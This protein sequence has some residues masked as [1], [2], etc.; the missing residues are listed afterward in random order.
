MEVRQNDEPGPRT[1]RRG[2]LLGVG[3]ESVT[4]P[5]LETPDLRPEESC[6]AEERIVNGPFDEHL[7][8]RAQEGRHGQEVR[9][10][11]T[12]RR[13]DAGGLHSVPARD[14]FHQGR[15]SLVVG[16]VEAS[17]LSRA[18]ELIDLER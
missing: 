11:G 3:L 5:P 1:G 4:E 17:G 8:T 14:R 6:G 2:Q 12:G 16:P 10:G 13:A 18:G 9:P 7:V 15:V